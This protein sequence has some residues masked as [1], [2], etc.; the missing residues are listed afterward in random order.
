[1]LELITIYKRKSIYY[2]DDLLD[3][4][5]KYNE[6]NLTMEEKDLIDLIRRYNITPS[7]FKQLYNIIEAMLKALKADGI[8]II[9][10]YD[11][12]N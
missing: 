2:A 6:N 10:K 7:Q 9:E 8:E 3:L 1:M 5:V 11:K 4:K 12:D